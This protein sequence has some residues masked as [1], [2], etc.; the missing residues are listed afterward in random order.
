MTSKNSDAAEALLSAIAVREQTGRLFALAEAGKLEHFTLDL[1]AMPALT[2][3]VAEVTRAAYPTLD[4]PFHARWRH[5]VHR[6]EDRWAR[7]SAKTGW[8]SPADRA[9]AAFDLA[10]T[11]VLL[12]AGAGSAWHYRDPVTGD[13]V[14]RSE[15][16]ALASFDM[17]VSGAFSEEPK[18]PL[19]ADAK[20]LAALSVADLAQGF[21]VAPENPLDGLEGRAALLNAL[22]RAC[23]AAPDLRDA[24]GDPRPG[25]LF[26]RLT[27]GGAEVQAPAI[28]GAVLRHLGGIWPSRLSLDGVPLGDCWRYPR[29]GDGTPGSDLVPF[30][31][32]SQWLSYSLIEP[33]Q[34]AGVA[35]ANIDGLTGLAEYRNGGLF[36][37]GRVILPKDRAILTR[38]HEPASAVV[39]EW[40]ALTVQLLDRIAP[41]VRAELGISDDA[42]PLA[43]VL[44]GGTWA[45]GRVL[46]RERR[47]DGG[48]PLRIIS[49]GTV[50]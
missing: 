25:A 32:L 36:L 28:L 46:A 42:F 11:S 16:L 29:L 38:E 7:L 41:L 43:K 30:H 21:Q 48:P 49:D 22:G 12:D 47:A 9:R 44:E 8:R 13:A 35:V 3:R 1:Q 45:T 50:F 23:L 4:V 34:A 17:F 19:R 39:I 40:R 2:R 24:H 18:D 10:I 27:A 20:R 5:F 31:K 14:G 33:M 26:D 6:G 37:D 15:G